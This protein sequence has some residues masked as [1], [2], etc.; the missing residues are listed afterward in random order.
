MNVSDLRGILTY[1]PQFREKVFVIAIDGAI[2][3][4]ENFPNILI[5][6]AVLRSLNIRVV[7]VH[8]IARQM[9]DLA[10]TSGVPLSNIDGTGMEGEGSGASHD[11]KS[12]RQSG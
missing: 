6:I 11:G 8:G 12:R 9:E 3:A 1:V 5:D 10:A 4:H 7:I 2:A